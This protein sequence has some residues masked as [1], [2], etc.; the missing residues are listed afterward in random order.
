MISLLQAQARELSNSLN[1]I[2]DQKTCNLIQDPTE[3]KALLL[4]ATPYPEA[5]IEYS[6][7]KSCHII[8]QLPITTTQNNNHICLQIDNLQQQNDIFLLTLEDVYSGNNDSYYINDYN[9]QI[10]YFLD[11]KNDI[12]IINNKN[13]TNNV[14][15]KFKQNTYLKKYLLYIN[16]SYILFEYNI[17]NHNLKILNKF[18]LQ[19]SK[20]PILKNIDILLIICKKKTKK[21]TKLQNLKINNLLINI[22]V[23]EN[24]YESNKI[25]PH[26]NCRMFELHI[27]TKNQDIEN[28]EYQKSNQYYQN[29]QYK[30]FFIT[31]QKK[32]YIINNEVFF[33]F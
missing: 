25:I 12:S 18:N 30:N 3:I 9:E 23:S 33:R 6:I 20:N 16:G 13:N 4:D 29:N 7:K 8:N 5:S 28:L 11:F 17:E 32:C 19:K 10:S 21:I 15:L 31:I 27:K 24:I 26:I 1:D 14:I 2:S 22:I